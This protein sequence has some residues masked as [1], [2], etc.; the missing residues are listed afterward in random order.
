MPIAPV[1]AVVG[2]KEPQRGKEPG[3][4]LAIHSESQYINKKVERLSRHVTNVKK[5]SNP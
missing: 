5:A 2:G 4:I 3:R 1:L